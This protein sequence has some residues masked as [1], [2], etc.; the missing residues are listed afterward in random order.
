MKKAVKIILAALAA[1]AG[2]TAV[3]FAVMKYR[4]DKCTCDEIFD[5]DNREDDGYGE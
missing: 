3:V 1:G 4:H 2:I 5:Y